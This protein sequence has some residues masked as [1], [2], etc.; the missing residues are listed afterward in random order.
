MSILAIGISI[1]TLEEIFPL[2]A[3]SGFFAK[4]RNKLR[5]LAQLQQLEDTLEDKDEDNTFQKATARSLKDNERRVLTSTTYK[6]EQD[7][8]TSSVHTRYFISLKTFYTYF[9]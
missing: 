4:S 5:T 8:L 1:P 2:A 9:N 7:D 3:A 6:E